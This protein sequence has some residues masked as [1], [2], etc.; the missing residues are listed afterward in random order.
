M[1]CINYEKP[2]ISVDALFP[3]RDK[4]KNQITVSIDVINSLFGCLL[5]IKRNRDKYNF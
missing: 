3:G 4:L 5:E 1:I 2:G